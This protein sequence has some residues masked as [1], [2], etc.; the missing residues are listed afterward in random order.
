MRGCVWFLGLVATLALLPLPAPAQDVGGSSS[1]SQFRF[2]WSVDQARSGH[3]RLSGYVQ[4]GSL[5]DARRILLRVEQL[6]PDA[7]PVASQLVYVA[8]EVQ[9]GGRS[10]FEVGVPDATARYRISIASLDWLRCAD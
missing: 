3:G 2:E 5:M 6:A 1:E 9:R 8:G 7:R 4:N 10:Y